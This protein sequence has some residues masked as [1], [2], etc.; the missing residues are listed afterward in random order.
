MTITSADICASERRSN[1]LGRGA[2]TGAAG[3][4]LEWVKG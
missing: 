3:S 1:R 2:A 4:A